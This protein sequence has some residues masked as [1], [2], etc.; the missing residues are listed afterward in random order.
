MENDKDFIKDW[1]EGKISPQELQSKK[2]VQSQDLEELITRTTGLHVPDTTTN[3]QA[4]EKL[5]A[6]IDAAP[7]PE[8]RVVTMNRWMPFSIAASV[9]LLILAFFV[10]REKT[11]TTGLAE[12]TV[13]TLPDGSEVTL[14]AGSKISF[15]R[16][17]WSDDRH[18]VLEGEAFFQVTKGNSFT[19]ESEAGTVTVLGTSFNVSARP[20]GLVV[21][22]YTGRVKVARGG[23]EVILTK[24]L[25]T[26]QQAQGLVPAEAFDEK[27]TTWRDGDF[28]FERVPLRIVMEELER[29]YDVTIHFAGDGERQYTGFFNNKDLDTALQMVFRP[30]A[31]EYKHEKNQ[32]IVQ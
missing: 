31:L 12:T 22:C 5:T 4:W 23:D 26:H 25:S 15:A 6:R 2:N 27:R 16:F 8:A 3:E 11:V 14:N 21:A 19:V 18:V 10:F 13:Y 9:S 29:Q 1:L 30:M 20:G 7:K 32:I 24:G 28:H 17:G